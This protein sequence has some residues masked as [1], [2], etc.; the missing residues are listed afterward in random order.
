[1]KNSNRKK[2]NSLQRVAVRAILLGA[3]IFMLVLT[4]VEL[5]LHVYAIMG[6]YKDEAEHEGAFVMSL[7]D[8]AYIERIFAETKDNYASIPEE[9]R[10]Q[11]FTDPYRERCAVVLDDEYFTARE[12]LVKCREQTG[13]RNIQMEFY[14]PENQRMVVVLDGDTPDF[15]YLPGQWLS[16]ELGEIESPEQIEYIL[17][18][19]WYMPVGY[20]EVSGWTATDY[21]EIFDT[22]G[23]LIGYLVMNIDINEFSNR[24][25]MFL[26]LYI[27][28]M[29]VILLLAA[30]RITG[31]LKKRI[32]N[33]VNKLAE[34]ARAYTRRDKTLESPEESYFQYLQIDTRDE[35]Q[36]LW[37]SMTDMEQDMTGTLSRIRKMTAERERLTQERARL[38]TELDIA[39]DIQRASLP[40]TFPAF[41]NRTEFDLFA[42]MTPAKVVGGDFYD[43]FLLDDDHLV[44]AIAD[45]SGKGIPAALFM[46]IG[47]QALRNSALQGGTPAEILTFV[48]NQ[49][50]ENNP[51][52]MFVTIWLGIL[53]ISTGEV[54]ACSA[55]HE[56]PILLRDNGKYEL[57]EEPHGLAC[58]ALSGELYENYTFRLP[59]GGK[60]FVYTDGVVE[61]HNGQDELFG[62]E[63]LVEELNRGV[64]D[65]PKA[66]VKR[67]LKL[68]NDFAGEC[69]QF[70][71]IT[72]LSLWYKGD[73]L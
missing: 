52:E 27:P 54:T 10:R 72:M 16:D 25:G 71:D 14:D 11:Q 4:A 61:A 47:K 8:P 63:K 15:A 73:N 55:G 53:T 70:D 68:I 32:I 26:A 49:L 40:S 59:P 19:D 3:C 34:A 17:S 44:L 24:M 69:E 30:I 65:T 42:R 46:M 13:M 66:S 37:D 6:N 29:I 43:F 45:V 18:S 38:Q 60:L 56:Y 20:G 9:L 57:F 62:A 51:N 7:M 21:M 67:I 22:R 36:Q 41:P 1:M 23:N 2:N 12:I 58:G 28:I 5:V 39:R 33:P 64:E 31:G 48:N 35:I 50:C